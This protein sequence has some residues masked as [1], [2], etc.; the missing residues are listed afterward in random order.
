MLFFL[1]IKALSVQSDHC[2]AMGYRIGGG[3]LVPGEMDVARVHPYRY[4]QGTLKSRG[5]V[6][7]PTASGGHPIPGGDTRSASYLVNDVH[8]ARITCKGI[9]GWGM[10]FGEDKKRDRCPRDSKPQLLL[11]YV[12]FLL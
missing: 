3:T 8:Q 12:L 1:R 6:R 10:T 4:D 7:T 2:R 5:L 11:G 9:W